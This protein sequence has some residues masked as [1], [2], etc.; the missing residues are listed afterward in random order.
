MY[1]ENFELKDINIEQ[2]GID[3]TSIR[4]DILSFDI[5]RLIK[6]NVK[7]NES[8][9]TGACNFTIKDDVFGKLIADGN[10]TTLQLKISADNNNLNN[11]DATEYKQRVLDVLDYLKQE[12]SLELDYSNAKIHKL[13]LNVTLLLEQPFKA[14]QDPIQLIYSCL[15]LSIYHSKNNK[16]EVKQQVWFTHKNNEKVIETFTIKNTS[17]QLKIYDK[18]KQLRDAGINVSNEYLRLEYTF[19]SKSTIKNYIDGAKVCNVNNYALKR[20]F[21]K[22]YNRDIRKQLPKYFKSNQKEL[23]SKLKQLKF[24]EAKERYWIQKFLLYVRS[25]DTKRVLP[26][27]FDLEQLDKALQQAFKDTQLNYKESYKSFKKAFERN[28]YYLN[29]LSNNKKN[30]DFITRKIETLR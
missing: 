28:E 20:L 9:L 3:K 26:L 17:L 13:E 6:N 29:D 19:C 18:S 25:E 16:N 1:K 14:Y 10:K 12:Y 27:L 30:L 7:V 24:G 5:D 23:V 4:L 8:Q 11:L 21:F 22:Y 2:I 15:P